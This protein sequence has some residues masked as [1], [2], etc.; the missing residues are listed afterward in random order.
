MTTFNATTFNATT[1]NATTF[2]ATTSIQTRV[3]PI[4]IAPEWARRG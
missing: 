2:N 1:S 4:P 3:H